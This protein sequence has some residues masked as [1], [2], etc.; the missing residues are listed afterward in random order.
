MM[1]NTAQCHGLV[2]SG[3]SAFDKCVPGFP[4]ST[5][6]PSTFTFFKKVAGLNGNV[7]F[8]N[9][10][11]GL[12]ITMT[13]N[14]VAVAA[15]ERS[16]D[17][18][19][20][21]V[22]LDV[23]LSTSEL[24]LKGELKQGSLIV[25]KTLPG[26]SVSLNEQMLKVTSGG[27]FVFG[28]HRDAPAQQVLTVTGADG[29]TSRHDLNII[30]R[31]YAIQYIEGIPKKIMQPSNKDLQ[32]IRREIAMVRKAR[33]V[34]SDQLAFSEP[35]IWPTQGPITGVYGSQ[36]YYNGEPRRPHYGI[37]IAAATGTDVV[38]PASGIIT[39]IH[40]DMFYSGGTIIM[41][42]GFGISSTFIHL[43]EVLVSEG[44]P[45]KQ[46]DVIGKVGQS[47]RSTGPHLDWRINWFSHRLD[48]AFL[49][50]LQMPE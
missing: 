46:G 2:R 35:F 37:D 5:S 34:D 48:P 24:T 11:L 49:I 27:L 38:A 42:H 29:K 3:D 44:Q 31:Q 1:L 36:R 22:P 18:R 9:A 16:E 19:F 23:S 50:G 45:V 20:D 21:Q 17:S 10:I 8:F 15:A 39:L 6:S 43:S 7:R 25:G 47:G 33:T 4:P 32:R 26:S 40:P 28:F 12:L 30:A 13:L 14:T 41:D